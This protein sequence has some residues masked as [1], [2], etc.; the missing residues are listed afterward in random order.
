MEYVPRSK[1]PLEENCWDFLSHN[2]NFQVDKLWAHS[3]SRVSAVTS[4]TNEILDDN[5]KESDESVLLAPSFEWRF[6]GIVKALTSVSAVCNPSHYHSYSN[7]PIIA[8]FIETNKLYQSRIWVHGAPGAGK[9]YL[10]DLISKHN[11]LPII[12]L[13]SLISN[14][15]EKKDEKSAELEKAMIPNPDK[16]NKKKDKRIP[17]EM[18]VNLYAEL[19]NTPIY[20]NRGFILD[21]FPRTLE[22]SKLLFER[23][24]IKVEHPNRVILLRCSSTQSAERH[25]N[26]PASTV[27]QFHNDDEGL[28]DLSYGFRVLG[29]KRRWEA[30][31]TNYD[32]NKEQCPL[33]LIESANIISVD[34]LDSIAATYEVD[35]AVRSSVLTFIDAIKPAHIGL[36]AS[37]LPIIQSKYCSSLNSEVVNSKIK[38]ATINT[39]VLK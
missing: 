1:L 24:A 39:F 7:I 8:Q 21:G 12:S 9:S 18:V 28:F 5:Q 6:F 30:Y 20:R 26:L 10:S 34:T 36:K 11:G 19:L 29:F 16:K 37:L 33:N 2:Y 13:S 17:V 27:V 38:S 31:D 15:L 25:K 4:T 32:I 23:S 22:E 3:K 14:A 35:C